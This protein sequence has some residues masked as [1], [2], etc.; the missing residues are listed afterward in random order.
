[1][2]STRSFSVRHAAV[3][4][5]CV[6]ALPAARSA[7]AAETACSATNTEVQSFTVALAEAP[8]TVRV[9]APISVP[10]TVRRAAAPAPGVLVQLTLKHGSRAQDETVVS[11]RTD[12]A[13]QVSLAPRVPANAAGTLWASVFAYAPVVSLPCHQEV[14]EYGATEGPWGRVVR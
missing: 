4:A 14:S 5:A 9:G 13:G 3:L 12:A 1:M 10:V 2:Q 8:T 11:G 7:V 6:L